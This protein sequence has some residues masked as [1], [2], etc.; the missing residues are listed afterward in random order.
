VLGWLVLGWLVLGWLVLGWLVLGWLVLTG[1]AGSE[2]ARNGPAGSASWR[3]RL[4]ACDRGPLPLDFPDGD[5]TVF[6]ARF[7]FHR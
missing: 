2:L 7:D 6:P 5:I 4:P 1:L 3:R